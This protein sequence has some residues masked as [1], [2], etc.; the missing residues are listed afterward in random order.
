MP[1]DKQITII[2]DA[3]EAKRSLDDGALIHLTN[4]V[5][6]IEREDA[7][8]LLQHE[9]AQRIHELLLPDE[10]K[11]ARIH[12]VD[13]AF[14]PIEHMKGLRENGQVVIAKDGDKTVG[15]VGFEFR[16]VDK[17]SGRSVFEIRRVGVRKDYEGQGIGTKLHNAMFARIRAM[18]PN[19]LVLV[20]A[21][22]PA[23]MKICE[24]M[25]YQRC[26]PRRA[27]ALQHGP[28]NLEEGLA[29]F[30]TT[31]GQYFLCDPALEAAA[32]REGESR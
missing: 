8:G 20:E 30:A 16:R 31:G 9:A 18:D 17:A 22:D 14:Y 1:P 27:R 10:E 29:Y 13:R 25:G 28:E 23:M 26:D 4:R 7:V 5:N 3:E 19:C 21:Q 15:M 2:E 24:N 12:E 32:S 6:K 11:W